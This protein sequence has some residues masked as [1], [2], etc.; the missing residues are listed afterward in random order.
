MS[1]PATGHSFTTSFFG[2][3]IQCHTLQTED[4]LR[5]HALKDIVCFLRVSVFGEPVSAAGRPAGVVIFNAAQIGSPAT[6]RNPDVTPA[7]IH[8]VLRDG[9]VTAAASEFEVS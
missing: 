6:Y 5:Q 1:R 9:H 4:D 7:G 2:M 8:L 3:L